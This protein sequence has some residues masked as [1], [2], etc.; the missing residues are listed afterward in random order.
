ML[1]GLISDKGVI[2]R[3]AIAGGGVI[4]PTGTTLSSWDLLT[5]ALV[6]VELG[7]E[8]LVTVELGLE[9]LDSAGGEGPFTGRAGVGAG[10]SGIITSLG[11][12]TFTPRC[13]A[14][15]VISYKRLWCVI[16]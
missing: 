14:P 13:C 11:G 2:G 10:E 3:L 5:I 16:S 1:Q 6:T 15:V 8:G 7:L 9:G 4:C 12:A